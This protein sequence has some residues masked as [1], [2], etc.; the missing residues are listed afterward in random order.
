M[1]KFTFLIAL[2]FATG[3]VFG[4]LA[5]I[6]DPNAT[7]TVTQAQI[8]AWG[9]ANQIMPNNT[10]VLNFEGIGNLA[11]IG[12][13]YNGG[14]GPNVGVYFGGTTLALI[15]EDAGGSGNFANEPS[16]NTVMFFLSGGGATMNVP[17]GFTTG[18]SFYYSS[19]GQGTVYV[20]EGLDGKG[21]L[22][23]TQPFS[24]NYSNN[25]CVGDPNGAYCH[26][27]PMGVSFAGV[28]KSV[29]FTG[30]EDHCAF[31]D[32][33]FGSITPGPTA[34]PTMSQWGLIFLALA[35][36]GV[37]T[38]YILRRRKSEIAI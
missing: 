7:V 33:T 27:D 38:A 18:F 2:M 35:L 4:Q 12:N 16:P 29:S 19:N 5:T 9:H 22:L 10:I 25:S 26:W 24:S 34:V 21:N 23:A 30:V 28:A 11:S 31:D 32:V 3:I 1:K 15:D 37:G 20:Y 17:A 36:L 6:H 14:G 13:Y 8:N